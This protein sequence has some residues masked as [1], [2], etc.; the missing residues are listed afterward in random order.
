V[1]TGGESL[2]YDRIMHVAL[3]CTLLLHF[4]LSSHASAEPLVCKRAANPTVP[5]AMF[6]LQAARS[7][8]PP[9]RLTR[10]FS[11][12]EDDAL[13]ANSGDDNLTAR[14]GEPLLMW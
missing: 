2:T 7:G 13:A 4:H 14:A 8:L 10:S 9:W 11:T 3:Q 6:P 1:G 12:A 5:A